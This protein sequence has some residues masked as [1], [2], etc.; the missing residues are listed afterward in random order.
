MQFVAGVY[1]SKNTIYL[2]TALGLPDNEVRFIK[3]ML[4]LTS[5]S[6]TFRK[7]GRYEWSDDVSK[8]NV[9]IVNAED[10]TSMQTW[11]LLAENKPSPILMLIT[12][13][14]KTP[15]TKYYFTRPYGPS[16]VL[17][18]LDKIAKDLNEHI[19]EVQT[20]SSAGKSEQHELFRTDQDIIP[21]RHRALVIDDSATVRKQLVL[22]L[23]SFNIKVDPAETGEQGLEL[24]QNNHYDIIF[25]DVV[26]PGADGY[27]VC[28]TIRKQQHT[29]HTP[30]VM[31]TSK[32]SPFDKMRG[33]LSGCN[34]YLIKPVDYENF[35]QILE[36]YLG[37]DTNNMSLNKKC[38]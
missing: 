30:I 1:M 6:S 20:F 3:I 32:S 34:N 12:A 28:K 33:S 9:V 26:M 7:Q 8:A 15:I 10:D 11:H 25:L 27:H 4:A 18:W 36:G 19:P 38:A 37:L 13:T 35:Y 29:K 24:L 22:E 21:V 17:M 31:L 14:E 2:V 5:H 23:G 16:K